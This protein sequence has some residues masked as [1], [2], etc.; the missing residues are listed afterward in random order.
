MNTPNARDLH[1]ESIIID[2]LNA[3]NFFDPRV[4]PRLF[5]GGITAV[6]ATVA[7]WHTPAEAVNLMADLLNV[8]DE[9]SDILMQAR[10]VADIH[11]AKASGRVGVIAGFQGGEPIGA[12]LNMLKLYHALGVRIIQLTYNFRNLIGCGCQEPEDTGLSDFGREAIAEMNRLGILIDLSHCGIRT[13]REA[14]DAS[15]GPVAFTHA[16]ALALCAMRRNKSDEAVKAV[17]ARGGMVGV[18]VFPPM[19]TCSPNASLD[20]YVRMI[21]HY[22][23]LVGVDHVGLGPDFME[24]MDPLVA[25]ASLK[26]L[27]ADTL[28]AFAAIPPTLGFESISACANVTAALLA[29]GYSAA[30]TRKIMGENWLNLYQTVWK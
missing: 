8:I 9:R 19:L 11:A 6:N 28:K 30:D 12:N 4:F 14:I 5:A 26:G 10:S 24:D 29:R 16:N 23:N 21:D 3:S 2:G 18:V 27:P 22:V 25:A 13:T 15:A 7:A 17:A 1:H 20:D